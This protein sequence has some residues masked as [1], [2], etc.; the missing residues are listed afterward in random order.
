[1][2]NFLII[3][4]PHNRLN[5]KLLLIFMVGCICAVKVLV[6]RIMVTREETFVGHCCPPVVKDWITVSYKTI[7]ICDKHLPLCQNVRTFINI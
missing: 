7:L 3:Y 2:N 5:V 4:S 1:M 6:S